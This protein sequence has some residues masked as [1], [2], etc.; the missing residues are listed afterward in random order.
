MVKIGRPASDEVYA[1]S[2][3][4]PAVKIGLTKVRRCL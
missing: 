4:V 3:G 2:M 1:Y